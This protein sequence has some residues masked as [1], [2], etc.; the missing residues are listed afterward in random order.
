MNSNIAEG[1]TKLEFS[2]DSA[3]LLLRQKLLFNP[4][5]HVSLVVIGSEESTE[6]EFPN[7][8][9]IKSLDVP[10]IDTFQI[11]KNIQPFEDNKGD[12]KYL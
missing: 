3:S 9:F 1:Q 12:C 5:D 6:S 8:S 11:I 4:K 2:K 7:V 10:E